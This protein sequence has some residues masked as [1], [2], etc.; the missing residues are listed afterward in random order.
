METVKE[1][2]KLHYGFLIVVC[3]CVFS[4]TSV[5]LLFGC[6]GIFY[7]PVSESLG[8]SRGTFALTVTAMSLSSSVSMMFVSRLIERYKLKHILIAVLMMQAACFALQS[9][10][11][12]VYPFYFTSVVMGFVSAYMTSTLNTVVLNRWFR[13]KVGFFIGLASSMTG[14]SGILINPLAGNF[15]THFGWEKTYLLYAAIVAFIALPFAIFV[16]KDDPRDVGLKPYGIEELERELAEH[17]NAEDIHAVTGVPVEKAV[18][19]SAFIYVV[20][21]LMMIGSA[22][23]FVTFLPSYASSLGR[24]LAF[25]AT[26]AG[27][28]QIG[29]LVGKNTLGAI[30]D[31]NTSVAVIIESGIAVAGL[32][33]MMTFGSVSTLLMQAGAAMFGIIYASTVLNPLV[34]IEAFGIREYTKIQARISLINGIVNA[35]MSSLW[36]FIADFNDGDFTMAIFLCAAFCIIGGVSA[37]IGM[38]KG[39]KLERI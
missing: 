39:R 7:T 28:S 33:L 37:I 10:F 30:S 4:F 12:S 34:V 25:A 17:E 13:K 14:L 5:A 38:K 36:G 8:I 19:S 3:C 1:K 24:S 32:F 15:M 23:S 22:S 31:K 27:I 29:T 21:S 18:R 11:K 2:G 35:A 9:A 6:A 26:L 20:F 16:F